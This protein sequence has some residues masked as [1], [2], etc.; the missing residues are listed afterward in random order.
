MFCCEAI[1]QQARKSYRAHRPCCRHS[2]PVA[3]SPTGS[4]GALD[5]R[6]SEPAHGRV[7]WRS[8]TCGPICSVAAWWRWLTTLACKATGQ[9]IRSFWTGWP[10]ELVRVGWFASTCLRTIV[11]RAPIASRRPCAANLDERDPLNTLLAGSRYRVEAEIVRDLFFSASGLLD[12][13]RRPDDLPG[14]SRLVRDIAYKY[15]IVWPTS[16]AR[17]IATAGHVH[18]FPPSNPYPSL[19][20]FDAPEGTNCGR[21]AQSLE[22]AAASA[23]HAERPSV[24]GKCPGSRSARAG[25]RS[26]RH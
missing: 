15:Q 13:R 24:H 12:R 21:P 1:S 5:G 2:R 17:Q 4:I 8:T 7:A 26:G 22:H 20:M 19:V 18:S 6:S 25:R 23:H 9:A 10:S 3:R 11:C 14:H 16:S